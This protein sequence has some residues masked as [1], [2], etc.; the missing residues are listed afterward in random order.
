V[1]SDAR[2]T[3]VSLLKLMKEYDVLSCSKQGIRFDG[4]TEAFI[5]D[6]LGEDFLEEFQEIVGLVLS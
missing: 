5:I 6:D 4:S 3:E 1:G 2:T